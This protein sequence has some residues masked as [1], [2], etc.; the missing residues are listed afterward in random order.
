M[1]AFISRGLVLGALALIVS[2]GTAAAQGGVPAP[3]VNVANPPARKVTIWD[4]Y[5]GRL[6]ASEQVEIRARVSGFIDALHFRDGQM[7]NKGDLLFTI[8]QRPYLLAVEAGRA[9]VARAEAQVRLAENEVERAEG[10]TRNQTIT[11]RDLDQRRSNLAVAVA[12]RQAAGASLKTAELNLEWSEVRAPIAGRISDRKVDVGNLIAG[13]QAGATLL[14][15]IVSL[16]PIYVTF[17]ASEA[18]YLRYARLFAAGARPSGRDTANPVQVRLADETDWKRMGKMDFVD[19]QLNARS[20]TIR[21]RA[22]LENKD[23]F[24]APGT[25][26]RLRLYGGEMEALLVPDQAIVSD[27]AR[28]IVLTVGA[29]NKVIPKPVELGPIVEGLRVVRSGLNP[30]DRVIINGLANPMVRP[31]VSVNPQPGEIK[32]A[33][34]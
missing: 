21:G 19:N 16:D 6:D 25:F 11:A 34:G 31:G 33:G 1:V 27:Q 23:Q 9:E 29:D 18:D 22:I 3:M 32:I 26:V 17:E 30:Q 4:E 12:A 10:L 2:V 15:N 5:T 28:K 24:L 14:T 20:G 7:V 13:G 8:D